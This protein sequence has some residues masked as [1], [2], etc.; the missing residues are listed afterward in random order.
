MEKPKVTIAVDASWVELI[1]ICKAVRYGTVQ[2]VLAD[3]APTRVDSGIKQMK[4]DVPQVSQS[5]INELDTL[6]MND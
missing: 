2:V 4:L 3:G 5:A 6:A 1:K